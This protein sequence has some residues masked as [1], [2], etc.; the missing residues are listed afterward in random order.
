MPYHQYIVHFRPTATCTVC[1]RRV[2][3]RGYTT[4]VASWATF[5]VV[6]FLLVRT[7]DSVGLWIAV[8]AAVL[9]LAFLGDFWTFKN[10]SWDPLPAA[11]D[12][13]VQT[14]P[15]GTASRVTRSQ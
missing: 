2:R 9:L 14:Q 11:D 15:S 7:S 12:P 5:T 3:L 4:L 10:L 1:G 8:G 6:V 13:L